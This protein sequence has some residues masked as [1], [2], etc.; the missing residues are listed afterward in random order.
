MRGNVIIWI[1]LTLAMTSCQKDVVDFDNGIDYGYGRELSHGRIVLGNRLE[2]PYT[3]ENVTKALASLYP[4]KAG[5]V[6]V[7]AT[8]L[9]VRF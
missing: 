6:E 5:R 9:Y 8:D 7:E 3:T 2:N 4:T 1:I